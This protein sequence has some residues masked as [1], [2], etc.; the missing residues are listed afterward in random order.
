MQS[1]RET[2]CDLVKPRLH[3]S[4]S[5]AIFGKNYSLNPANIE[6][7][8]S[9]RLLGI[10]RII[11]ISVPTIRNDDVSH[12]SVPCRRGTSDSTIPR[13]CLI[14]VPTMRTNAVSHA[15]VSCRRGTSASTIPNELWLSITTIDPMTSEHAPIGFLKEHLLPNI[16]RKLL[17]KRV[18]RCSERIWTI[19]S[20]AYSQSAS[21]RTTCFQNFAT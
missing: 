16:L 18:S 1:R 9:E 13:I 7:F 15:S 3:F 14:S 2:G 8:K 19:G 20:F 11:I 17:R 21:R 4:L 5:L 6:R 12:A 10:P